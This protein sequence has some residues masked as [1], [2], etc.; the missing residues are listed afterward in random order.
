MDVQ[1][2]KK[3]IID[4]QECEYLDFKE[5]QYDFSDSGG[6]TKEQK[7]AEFI[8]DIVSMYNTKRDQTAYIILGVK[9]N[10]DK[11]YELKGV[12]NHI[13]DE[14]LQSKFKTIIEPVPKFIYE[15]IPYEGYQLA[16]ISIPLN[17]KIGPCLPLKDFPGGEK[18]ILNQHQLYVRRGSVNE[19]AN[20]SEQIQTYKWFGESYFMGSLN[21][22]DSDS[23]SE[24]WD[25]FLEKA[26]YF[27]AKDY[28]Y[29]LIASPVKSDLDLT[30]NIG[31]IDWFFVVDFDQKTDQSGLLN[32][33]RS[34]VESRRKIHLIKKGDSNNCNIGKGNTFWYAARGLIGLPDTL[35]SSERYN[36]WS[37][38]YSDELRTRLKDAAAC[39]TKPSVF[40]VL[41][42][43]SFSI[44]FLKNVLESVDSTFEER[45]KIIVLAKS[46]SDILIELTNDFECYCYDI[47]LQ[48]FAQAVRQSVTAASLQP[49]SD[50]VALPSNISAPL[51]IPKSK[52]IWLKEEL[53][54][55]H[56]NEGLKAEGN[57]P[58]KEFL[59][60]K[61]I[62]WYSLRLYYDVPRILTESLEK[63]IRKALNAR[64][65]KR[66]KLYHRPGSG[67]TTVAKR[68]LWN[69]HLEFPCLML[70]ETEPEL[71]IERLS[72]IAEQTGKAILVVVDA[73]HITDRE[74][75]KL[76]EKI[77][78][79]S[80]PVVLLEVI[81]RSESISD[82]EG[83]FYLDSRLSIQEEEDFIHFLG[84]EQPNRKDIL[85]RQVKSIER[86]YL[87]PFYLAL[88]TF[89]RDFEKIEEYIWQRIEPLNAYQKDV[90][91]FLS[92]AHY[93]G[94]RSI[95][96]QMFADVLSLPKHQAIKLEK[97]FPEVTL[98][99]LVHSSEDKWRIVHTLVAEEC[100]RQIFTPLNGDR[101]NWR[102][103]LSFWA[104]R[105]IEFCR[106]ESNVVSQVGLD[107]IY[108]VFI[109]RGNS[110]LLGSEQAASKRFS[111]LLDTIPSL[112]GRLNILKTLTEYYP[113]EAH[114]W[115]HL[116]R[117][118][119]I[120]KQDFDKALYALGIAIDLQKNDHVLFHMKGMIHRSKVY[121]MIAEKIDFSEVL[122]ESKKASEAF[123]E[124]RVFNPNDE[125]GY[126]SEVQMLL[127]IVDYFKVLKKAN[128]HVAAMTSISKEHKIVREAFQAIEELLEQVR[129]LRK[130]DN[131]SAHEESC[132]GQLNSFY[133]DYNEALQ[134][135]DSLLSR[136]VYLPPIKRQIVW[137]YLAKYNRKWSALRHREIERSI[138]LL[139]EN[140]EEEPSVESNLRLWFQAIRVSR[141]PPN[142]DAVIEKLSYWHINSNSL[143]SAYYLFIL[144]AIQAISGSI[145]AREAAKK[146]ADVTK[147]LSR[148]RSNRK[149]SFEWFGAGEGIKSLVASSELGDWLNNTFWDNTERLKRIKGVVTTIQGPEAGSITIESGLTAFYVPG[150]AGHHKGESENRR[151]SLFLGFSY[152]G[153]RAWQVEDI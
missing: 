25:V 81:R 49:T 121:Q 129:L 75:D 5:R 92:I 114:I 26:F 141:M 86:R 97:I 124:A 85:Q 3:L 84:R 11:S 37:R 66:I 62:S 140:L 99:I 137:T 19:I 128:S 107:F 96:A 127:K 30:E 135:W 113:S 1:L 142:I 136:D 23:R 139:E 34:M 33:C 119:D 143:E 70:K 63:S 16:I 105:F 9:K 38:M 31:C 109:K 133:G 123:L 59:R 145:Q 78:V 132:R 94:Q 150:R 131:P 108:Q 146:F 36:H 27:N 29:G 39:T 117:F 42:D 130:G 35:P 47:S 89:G 93:F 44:D 74:S 104:L 72:Y 69:L 82:N 138:I 12:V 53:E 21:E 144:N 111:E 28:N 10:L 55:V 112:D 90:L 20:G 126:I 147:Q 58:G 45:S 50:I 24:V 4:G 103:Y 65:S 116:G 151:V 73:S 14:I 98:E 83:K 60:G 120:Q 48:S 46:P 40:I 2:L 101:E 125:Y 77:A 51:E 7:R 32:Q 64:S 102:Q 68:I 88:I 52:I 153:L 67:A 43:E 57:D 106:G 134:R 115:A 148:N 61:E 110:E 95:P 122:Q 22:I 6:K 87:T 91:A 149:I 8:K 79:E 100:M 152:D 41:W 17:N 118:Y 18:R 13:D 80:K 56:L 15:A 76:Y 71:T 54:I